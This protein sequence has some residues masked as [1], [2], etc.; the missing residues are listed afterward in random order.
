VYP[1][2]TTLGRLATSE[3][4]AFLGIPVGVERDRNLTTAL[5]LTPAVASWLRPR[6]LSSSSFIL[7]RSLSSRDPVRT[8]DSVGAFILPQTL[9][10]SRT[11]E[12]GAGVDFARG[13]RQVFGDSSFI[14]RALAKVRPVDMSTR[15]SRSSTYDLTAFDP[16]LGYQ[17][18][19]GGLDDF[20]FQEGTPARGVAE[21]RTATIAG[22]ADLPAGISV[23]LS[24]ARTRTSRLQQV[25]NV[26]IV[27]ETSQLEWPVGSVRW[28][29][30][31]K[32]GVFAL[33]AVGANFR[34]RK[35]S[36][37][38]SGNNVAPQALTS[39]RS[40][41]ITPDLQ[42][43]FRNG[44]NLSVSLSDL[45]QSNAS[46]GN[47]TRLEQ[48]DLSGSLTYAFRMPSSI[49]RMRK[50]VRSSLSFL[51]SDSKSCLQQGQATE[52]ETVS[53]VSRKEIR[54]GLDTDLLK[55]LTGGLQVGYAL[56]DARHL[57]RRTSQISIIASFQLSLFAGDYR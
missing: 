44:L 9:N 50:Q 46:N 56:N 15:L 37:I 40:S 48:G 35:G 42:I 30:S 21:A 4:K 25:S 31:F 28:S 1:D 13:L 10:N 34:V 51:S 18:G 19:L 22:G 27:T 47:E 6:F 7:S 17:L 2:S 11:N 24:Q 3:R 8:G 54:G 32:K 41:S 55:T 39:I 52:C 38:Q 26:L 49:S 36:S 14:G 57:S 16:S 5:A 23:T 45:D 20:L 43:G 53:D 12:L 33:M 29:Q